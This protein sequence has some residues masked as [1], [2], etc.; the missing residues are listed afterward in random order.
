MGLVLVVAGRGGGGGVIAA[1][2][3]TYISRR[4]EIDAAIEIDKRF[5]LKERVSSALALG[6]ADRQ[7][8]FG[9]ALTADAIARI[10]RIDVAERFRWSPS[11]RALLP[12]ASAALAVG[13]LLVPDKIAPEQAAASSSQQ[14]ARK[15]DR[16][17]EPAA[18]QEARRKTPRRRKETAQGRGGLVHENRAR[19]S[20]DGEVRGDRS[21]ASGRE[22]EQF[23]RRDEG[24]SPEAGRFR[25]HEAGF[26]GPEKGE[27][28]SGGKTGRRAEKRQPA[29]RAEGDQPAQGAN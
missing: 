18:S 8:E 2:V 9:Q 6:E 26:G 14:A 3:W 29:G 4:T 19:C 13:L 12:V 17:I 24:A 1:A 23:G 11:R 16:T 10:N 25:P 5:E 21:Q 27:G 28:R 7:S 22:T 15:A 20:R